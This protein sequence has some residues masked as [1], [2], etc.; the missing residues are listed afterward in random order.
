MVPIT[1]TVWQQV[2]AE[3]RRCDKGQLRAWLYD[4]DLPR[5]AGGVLT[6]VARNEA[7]VRHLERCRESVARCA[8][9]ALGRLVSL[10]IRL[11]SER[12]ESDPTPVAG[13]SNGLRDD[14]TMQSFIVS[15]EN[16]MAHAAALQVLQ[17]PGGAYNPLFLHGPPGSGKTHLLQAICRAATDPPLGLP[18][19]SP[20]PPLYKGGVHCAPRAIYVSASE[21]IARFTECFEE[22]MP[23]RFRRRL[24]EAD[25]VALD[26]VEYFAGKARSQEEL[27]HVVNGLLNSGKQL[28]LA[29]DRSPGAIPGLEPRVASRLSAGLVVAM[30]SPGVESRMRIIEQKNQS[31]CYE[32]PQEALRQIAERCTP[33][34]LDGVLSRL[35][36]IAQAHSGRVT[37]DL[38]D[39]VFRDQAQEAAI[40]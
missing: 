19:W 26:D 20:S 36:E 11:D 25:L 35:D 34:E 29:A 28:V 4:L 3:L 6:V 24:L 32:C 40:A 17:E 13:R 39:E 8:Q 33:R 16:Q 38:V 15:Q 21:F 12:D 27:F 9:V 31:G 2:L 18:P 10:D 14:F 1:Q 37:M 7:Q 23:Q 22:A 30:D 5:L